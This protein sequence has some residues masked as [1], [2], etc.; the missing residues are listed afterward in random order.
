M[1]LVQDC[2]VVNSSRF[3]QGEIG[4]TWSFDLFLD[5][6]QVSGGEIYLSLKDG[7]LQTE[8]ALRC[9]LNVAVVPYIIN[10]SLK[11][12]LRGKICTM[13]GTM[14]ENQTLLQ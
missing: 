4:E 7:M 10:Q 2:V 13:L 14:G 6:L 11:V 3:H 1:S 5:L 8:L 12:L 9:S